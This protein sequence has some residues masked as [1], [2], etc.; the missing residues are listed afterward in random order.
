[1]LVKLNANNTTDILLFLSY[2]DVINVFLSSK[3]MKGLVAGSTVLWEALYF[4]F[5]Y[6]KYC[7]I[8]HEE[9]HHALI[10]HY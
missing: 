1:M 6:E 9:R 2:K 7:G 5:L 10:H 3:Y 4:G 8:L